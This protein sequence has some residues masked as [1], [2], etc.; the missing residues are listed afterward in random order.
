MCS[1]EHSSWA[2]CPLHKGKCICFTPA[3]CVLCAFQ[4]CELCESVL[5]L[6]CCKFRGVAG[7]KA[8]SPVI[9]SAVESEGPS[10]VSFLLSLMCRPW[11]IWHK[12]ERNEVYINPIK[13][14]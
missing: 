5:I 6:G 1:P 14:G 9:I 11:G 12:R 8:A 13:L 7:V 4:E 3:C 2:D 10:L